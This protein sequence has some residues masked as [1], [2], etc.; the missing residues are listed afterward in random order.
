MVSQ[1]E[2]HVSERYPLVMSVDDTGFMKDPTVYCFSLPDDG[3][4]NLFQHLREL[5]RVQ[6]RRVIEVVIF[7]C[8]NNGGNGVFLWIYPNLKNPIQF[9]KR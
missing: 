5:G 6:P 4:V 9:L 7:A 3:L 2:K 8:Q 1:K